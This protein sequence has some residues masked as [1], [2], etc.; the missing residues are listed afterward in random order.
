MLSGGQAQ[1]RPVLGSVA[2]CMVRNEQDIIEPFLRHTA[3]LVDMVV[4]LDNLSGDNTRDIALATARDLGNVIVT[5][6]PDSGYNQSKTMTLLLHE[7]Q[8]I[9]CA[10][11]VFFLDADEF[12]SADSAQALSTRLHDIPIG[13]VG[14]MPWQ[15]WAPDPGAD[16]ALSDPLGRIALRRRKEEPQYH[17][18]VLRAG[19]ASCIGLTVAQ[20]NH[21]VLGRNKKPVTATYL[22]DVPLIHIPLRSVEQMQAKGVVGWLANQNRAEG[23]RK[24]DAYQWRMLAERFDAADPVSAK[25]LTQAALG[26]AQKSDAVPVDIGIDAEPAPLPVSI[27]RRHSDGAF[28]PAGDLIARAREGT[29]NKRFELPAPPSGRSAGAQIEN[30]FEGAWHWDNIFLDRPPL[31]FVIDYF[32]PASVIDIG[33]GNG[34]YP[35]F[36]EHLGVRDILGVD[37]IEPEATVLGPDQ[38]RKVDLQEPFDAGR[39]FD[40]VI[41]L[42]VL[43]HITPDTTGT[44]LDTI[45]RHARETIV[46]SMAEPGQPG[47]GHINCRDMDFVLT[48]WAQRGWYPELALTLGVRA[49]S[50]MSWFR[51]NIVVLTRDM[52]VDGAASAH[53]RDIGS[54][55][56]KW[57]SQ[58]PGLRDT[59]FVEGRPN[60]AVGYGP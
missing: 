15:T 22:N 31:E 32:Q 5:D 46:F 45:A 18:A 25:E 27:T 16:P 44:A 13:Q 24:S 37:G 28:M 8:T 59:A 41:C 7:V 39:Q 14:L 47:N 9:V 60:M 26:Y 36:Y 29:P 42:E 19:G 48:E 57:W 55:P 30:A 40:L 49:L 43:E 2:L 50:S 52:D 54:R 12:I 21:V 53:L 3:G 34:V 58:G 17:K 23:V 51:R 56:Y 6:W 11:F 35:K 1:A 33:C 10:D 20:G 38:Y 4:V